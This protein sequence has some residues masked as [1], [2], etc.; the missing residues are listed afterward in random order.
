MSA[1]SMLGREALAMYLV[2]LCFLLRC[3]HFDYRV[4][5]LEQRLQD[6]LS[7]I[8]MVF[9]SFLRNCTENF[10]QL[11]VS[12]TYY[13]SKIEVYVGK[14]NERLHQM[15]TFPAAVKL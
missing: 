9:D 10:V 1:L 13:V 15:N 11:S 14:Q 7:P 8:G 12:E 2:L 4:T 5:L 6:K 3:T